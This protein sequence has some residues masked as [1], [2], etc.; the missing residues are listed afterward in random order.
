MTKVTVSV[1][2]FYL[3]YLVIA[4]IGHS[5]QSHCLDEIK[6]GTLALGCPNN[7]LIKLGR[8]FYGYSWS[9][10]CSFV[11]KDC[12]MDVPREDI[13]CLTTTNC[14]IRVI[15]HPLILQDC[16]NLAASYVQAEYECIA[17]YSL[18][19]VC[20]PQDTTLTY[21]FLSTPN[22]PHGFS[23]N[24]NCPCAL[25]AT[26]GYAIVLEVI[27]FRLPTCAE[28]G[29]ILW[30]GQDFQTKCLTQ[31]PL[32]VVSNVQQNVTLR[33]YTLSHM[34]HGGFLIKYSVLPVSNNATVRLQCYVAPAVSRSPMSTGFPS[35]DLSQQPPLHIPVGDNGMNVAIDRESGAEG[36]DERRRIGD[37][38]PVPSFVATHSNDLIKRF[39]SGHDDSSSVFGTL[40]EPKGIMSLAGVNKQQQQQFQGLNQTIYKRYLFPNSASFRRSNMTV[41]VICVVSAVIFLL[42]MINALI[43]FIFSL[44]PSKPKP[45]PPF[46]N[47]YPHA[48]T[49]SNQ[50]K[51][52]TST[53]PTPIH[54]RRHHS[55]TSLR[56]DDSSLMSNHLVRQDRILPQAAAT[57]RLKTLRSLLFRGH[58]TLG[59]SPMIIN[60]SNSYNRD[61]D[62]TLS[63]YHI[64]SLSQSVIES[65]LPKPYYEE[66]EDCVDLKSECSILTNRNHGL[67][68]PIKSNPQPRQ[69]NSWDDI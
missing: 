26:P 11:E 40:E 12:T 6:S 42:I 8:I 35:S 67:M 58:K 19:N 69:I 34:K 30:L 18:Q 15:E 59:M 31:D 25:F 61:L 20:Q 32:T 65:Q 14:T 50:T 52:T 22:Y 21:G 17:E 4:R 36:N 53:Y 9:N 7:Q 10:E 68:N 24:L 44:R 37:E 41:I 5:K 28:A 23:P 63:G 27:D 13:V 46:R 1:L 60:R 56:L 57:N 3:P 29:L 16:W 33:F 64:R 49:L 2:L 43:W 39:P 62:S 54:P 51:T 38:M 48:P 66:Q 45:T 47:F 55:Q